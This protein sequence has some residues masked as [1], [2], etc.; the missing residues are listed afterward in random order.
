MSIPNN[1]VHPPVVGQGF[2]FAV[3][4]SCGFKDH[5]DRATIATNE[6]ITPSQFI[7]KSFSLKKNLPASTEIIIIAE[8]FRANTTELSKIP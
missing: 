7:R 1:G 6:I 2:G 5:N 3:E 4:D 8:L